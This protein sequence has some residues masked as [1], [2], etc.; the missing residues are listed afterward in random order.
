MLTQINQEEKNERSTAKFIRFDQ[1]GIERFLLRTWSSELISMFD[2]ILRALNHAY[3]ICISKIRISKQR[4]CIST[5][6]IP[7]PPTLLQKRKLF[8]FKIERK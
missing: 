4:K 8:A 5:S 1:K 3:K 6:K 7:L 2:W